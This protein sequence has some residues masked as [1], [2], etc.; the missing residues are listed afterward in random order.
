VRFRASRRIVQVDLEYNKLVLQNN[1]ENNG[2]FNPDPRLIPHV[3]AKVSEYTVPPKRQ[4]HIREI[5]FPRIQQSFPVPFAKLKIGP[6]EK[7]IRA[8]I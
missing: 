2:Y 1:V 7:K 4:Y 3:T 8:T 6:A 5:K